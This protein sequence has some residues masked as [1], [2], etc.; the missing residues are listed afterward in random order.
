MMKEMKKAININE[1]SFQ[2]F[3]NIYSW[4]KDDA[5]MIRLKTNFE[6]CINKLKSEDEYNEWMNNGCCYYRDDNNNIQLYFHLYDTEEDR[7]TDIDL[8]KWCKIKNK[9]RYMFYMY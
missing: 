4:H 2:R 6:I 1:N 9:N 3:V 5:E 8:T 7:Y